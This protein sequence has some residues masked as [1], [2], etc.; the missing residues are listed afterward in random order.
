MGRVRSGGRARK[1]RQLAGAL[2]AG[3]QAG[4]GSRAPRHREQ[5]PAR[6]PR[7]V[8]SREPRASIGE[9]ADRLVDVSMCGVR[10]PPVPCTAHTHVYI[11]IYIHTHTHTRA[12]PWTSAQ[13][14]PVPYEY[15]CILYI[16]Y[17]PTHRHLYRYRSARPYTRQLTARALLQRVIGRAR[18]GDQLAGALGGASRQAEG[19]ARAPA[20]RE[21]TGPAPLARTGAPDGPSDQV[22]LRPKQRAN[23]RGPLCMGARVD[24]RTTPYKMGPP[25]ARSGPGNVCTHDGGPVEVGGS[26][27]KARAASPLVACELCAG[28]FFPARQ[29]ASL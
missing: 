4:R 6:A 22:P 9:A 20:W 25:P 24:A 26:M 12:P 27:W 5:P 1:G 10:G 15:I 16:S 14:P 3:R 28:H 23:L 2:G 13:G 18:G 17:L 11:Y 8:G 21:P 29:A 19:A 7:R